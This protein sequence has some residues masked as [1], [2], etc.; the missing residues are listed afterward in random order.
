MPPP[1][2]YLEANILTLKS[3]LDLNEI[4]INSSSFFSINNT[5]HKIPSTLSP[6]FTKPSLSPFLKLLDFDLR[7]LLKYTIQVNHQL[8]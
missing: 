8:F 4:L 6:K 2:K 3:P 7:R 1:L 5:E